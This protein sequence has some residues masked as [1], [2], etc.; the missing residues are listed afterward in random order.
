[1][2]RKDFVLSFLVTMSST[3]LVPLSKLLLRVTPQAKIK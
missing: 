1:M 2:L 3:P